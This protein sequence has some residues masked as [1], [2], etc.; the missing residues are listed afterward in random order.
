MTDDDLTNLGVG[1]DAAGSRK[2]RGGTSQEDFRR[3]LYERYVST[4][5]GDQATSHYQ[6]AQ[7]EWWRRKLLP[8]L[9]EIPR[10]KPLL[11]LGCG[12]GAFLRFLIDQGFSSIAGVDVSPEQVTLADAGKLPVVHEDAFVYLREHVDTYAAVVAIDF[13]EHFTR[14][15]LVRLVPLIY[16]SLQP[17]GRLLIQTINLGGLFSHQVSFGDLTHMTYLNEGSLSQLLRLSGFSDLHFV[18]TGP[19]AKDLKGAT[20]S[21][22]WSIIRAVAQACRLIETGK[23][24]QIWT[25]NQICLAVKT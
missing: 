1:S 14:D 11:E 6:P 22:L 23:R 3:L 17:G 7:G 18:E 20:R 25:E 12:S 10:D 5:L 8:L 2:S 4:H 13:L 9:A 19:V 24:Q 16:R 21:A 15:E